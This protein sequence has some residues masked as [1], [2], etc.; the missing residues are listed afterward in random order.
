MNRQA[1]TAVLG[2]AV[3]G[4]VLAACASETTNGAPGADA[5]ADRYR[6]FSTTFVRN[7]ETPSDD[8]LIIESDNNQAYELDMAGPCFGLDDSLALGI[9]SHTGMSQICDPL[10]VDIIF[11]NNVLGGRSECHVM[12]M[13]HLTGDE[14][15]KYLTP[16][17]AAAAAAA[18]GSSSSSSAHP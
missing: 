16:R 9:R 7:F 3:L 4:V 14:A 12:T 2:M 13:R 17:K 6:C 15:A 8:K 1:I 10:D 11:H 18:A 5:K